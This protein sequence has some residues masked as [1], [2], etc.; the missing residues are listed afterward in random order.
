MNSARFAKT[1]TSI[2]PPTEGTSIVLLRIWN[3]GTSGVTM[4]K[5]ECIPRRSAA[6]KTMPP[7]RIVTRRNS[8]LPP[9]LQTG[10][11]SSIV[12][13]VYSEK[14]HLQDYV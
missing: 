4:L 8:Y 6:D 2:P 12:E 10:E 9:L 5:P 7:L 14:T 13:T 11:F 3:S 1:P